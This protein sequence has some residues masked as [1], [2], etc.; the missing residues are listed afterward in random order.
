MD[1][2]RCAVFADGGTTSFNVDGKAYFLDGRIQSDTKDELYDRYPG[3]IGAK[4]LDAPKI[5]QAIL[6]YEQKRIEELRANRIESSLGNSMNK[7]LAKALTRE[8]KQAVVNE[9]YGAMMRR[10][11]WINNNPKGDA[12][13]RKTCKAGIADMERFL[14]KVKKHLDLEPQK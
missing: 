13:Y 7:H 4:M 14:A 6:D 3:E 9:A 1:I 11:Q 8:D 10:K 5:K 2:K 12:K